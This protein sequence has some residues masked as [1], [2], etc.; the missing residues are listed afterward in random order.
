MN[1]E[2]R[3]GCSARRSPGKCGRRRPS[4]RSAAPAKDAPAAFVA[5]QP[6]LRAYGLGWDL[7]DYRG[8]RLVSHTGG[9]AGYVSQT[10]L[11][12][13]LKLG[14]VVLT[15]QEVTAAYSAIA[16]AVIDHYLGVPDADWVAAHAAQL[17][18]SG[19]R[20]GGGQKGGRP[21]QARHQAGAAAGGLRRPLPRRL[22]RRY[23][24]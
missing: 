15:N 20:R 1:A 14:V 12:P 18:N 2:E 5:T 17:K 19:Q 3:R 21:A 13:E 4:C 22:V 11:I 24:D 7:R 9:L 6:N 8:K 23:A 16:N 10:S